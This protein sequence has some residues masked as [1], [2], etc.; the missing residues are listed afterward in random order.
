MD[1]QQNGQLNKGHNKN[2]LRHKVVYP[3]IHTICSILILKSLAPIHAT[4]I[5]ANNYQTHSS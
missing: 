1:Q 3:L 2:G 5:S 4:Q